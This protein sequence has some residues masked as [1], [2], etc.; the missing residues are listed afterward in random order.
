MP[1]RQNEHLIVTPYYYNCFK[2]FFFIDVDYCVV[3]KVPRR[4][5]R[6]QTLVEQLRAFSDK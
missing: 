5:E 3:H 1:C 4:S 6:V 2:N